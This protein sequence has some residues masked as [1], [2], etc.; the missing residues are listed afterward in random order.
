[1]LVGATAVGLTIGGLIVRPPADPTVSL[2]NAYILTVI[3]LITV[4]VAGVGT[5][6]AVRRPDHPLGWLFLASSL[7]MS[8]SALGAPLLIAWYEATGNPVAGT[9]AWIGGWCSNLSV[10]ILIIVIPLLYPNGKL[11]S[12]RWRPLALLAGI[13]IAIVS[14][15]TAV[16]PGRMQETGFIN[17]IG[18]AGSTPFLEAVLRPGLV[19]LGVVLVAVVVSVAVRF[20]RASAIER[21]QLKWFIYPA[22]IAALG[23]AVSVLELGPISDASWA[24]AI[25]ATALIPPAMGVAILRYHVFE[26][27]RIASRTLAY[28]ILSAVLAG[29]YLVGVLVLQTL[30]SPF[31]NDESP[32]AVAGSTL[33]A[34][35]LMQPLRARIK[36][37]VDRR[38]N[39][40]RFDAERT[41]A[42]FRTRIRDDTDLDRIAEGL[43]GTAAQALAPSS[44]SVWLRAP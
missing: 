9:L 28:A 33:L 30:L 29:I 2:E 44:V 16:R 37:F 22:A 11:P 8:L 41:I 21:P 17:P 27:D 23:F 5:L 43:A 19:G 38:F 3:L 15:A 10:S 35:V 32:V 4:G 7:L 24:L 26:I 13:D 20:R 14:I 1:M 34:A 42:A 25:G 31:G 12:P 40:S 36:R 18:I 6:I 39:R